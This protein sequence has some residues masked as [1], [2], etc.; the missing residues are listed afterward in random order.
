MG[1]MGEDAGQESSWSFRLVEW[2]RRRVLAVMKPYAPSHVAII[3]DG[4]RRWARQRCLAAYAGHPRGSRKLT[5]A[6]E[7][8]AAAGVETLTVY[9]FSVDNFRRSPD[10]V[11][12]LMRL[13]RDKFAEWLH[14]RRQRGDGVMVGAA[15]GQRAVRVRVIGQLPLLP[16]TVR[17]LAEEINAADAQSEW[18][19]AKTPA[20]RLNVCVAYDA[21]ADVEQAVRRVR[22]GLHAGLLQ[23][24]DVDAELISA[25]MGNADPAI[26]ELSARARSAQVSLLIR[27]SAEPRLSS[28]LLWQTCAVPTSESDG[29]SDETCVALVRALWPDF[30]WWDFVLVLVWYAWRTL[31]RTRKSG[32]KR[33]PAREAQR[34]ERFLCWCDANDAMARKTYVSGTEANGDGGCNER[35]GNTFVEGYSV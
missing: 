10:E 28:F 4:N 19:T 20:L 17:R 13:A 14:E 5:E 16:P 22:A 32:E 33:P 34:V 29:S 6:A 23:P 21:V 24:S 9:A 35:G 27:T 25:L 1:R 2:L 30:G 12:A 26:G 8:C 15:G 31:W 3:M 7:W 11:E 18:A